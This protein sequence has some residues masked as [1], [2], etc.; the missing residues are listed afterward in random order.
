MFLRNDQELNQGGGAAALSFGR[1][2]VVRKPTL[3]DRLQTRF[4]D[5]DLVP[6]LGANIGSADWFRGAVTCALLCGSAV[7]LAPALQRPL[8]GYVDAPLRGTDYEEVRALSVTPLALGANSGRRMGATRL[9]APL[10]DT[11]ERPRLEL[12]FNA[13][14]GAGL[15]NG[16]ERSGVGKDEA[17]RVLAMVENAVSLGDVPANTH[18]EL[19]LGRRPDKSQPRPLEHVA[20]RAAFDKKLRIDRTG[21]GLALQVQ[22]IA[23]DHTPLRV[24]AAIGGSLYRTA[25]AMGVPAK[26]VETFLKTVATRLPIGRLGS[27]GEFELI[28]EREQAATGETRYGDLQLAGIYQGRSKTQLVRWDKDGKTQWLDSAGRGE[29]KGGMN[30]PVSGRLTST[31][32][33]RIHPILHTARMHKGLDIA[34]PFGSPIHAAMDGV[35]AM[36][37]R[38][39]GYGNFVKLAHAGGVA[40]GYGHMSRI[41]VR[42]GQRVTRG[43]TIGLVGSTGLSTGPHLHYEVWKNGV[44]INPGK[45]SVSTVDQLA[46]DDLRAFKSKVAHLLAVP[47]GGKRG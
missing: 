13:A 16:L 46:G 21:G 44:A 17:A 6:D 45:I 8:S 12:A 42:P 14:S 31:F 15:Q 18:V 36:A 20:F 34:A 27:G 35:V 47:V 26:L 38:A 19:V 43:Q 29:R 39:G 40:S 41:L 24:R 5:F 32:G 4:P 10:S 22:P 1:A 30:M 25:R 33:M 3:A 11:P 23:I 37:G 9:V 28:A 2:L 7:L